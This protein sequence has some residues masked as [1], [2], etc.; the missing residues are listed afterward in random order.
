MAVGRKEWLS[1]ENLAMKRKKP[2]GKH[3]RRLLTCL[4]RDRDCETPSHFERTGVLRQLEYRHRLALCQGLRKRKFPFFFKGASF[5]PGAG[6]SAPRKSQPVAAPSLAA[7]RSRRGSL[8]E[9]VGGRREILH[10]KKPG[11][12]KSRGLLSGRTLTN[13][14]GL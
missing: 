3:S 4:S 7:R 13:F 11:L 1:D 5:S 2:P 12:T 9:A 8:P 6:V 14:S 10:K